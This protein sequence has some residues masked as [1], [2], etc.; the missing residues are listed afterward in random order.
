MEIE[1]SLWEDHCLEKHT[2]EEVVDIFRA[3]FKG[4]GW[5]EEDDDEFYH[6]AD[7]RDDDRGFR[8]RPCKT[9]ND[10]YGSFVGF[11]ICQFN[12]NRVYHSFVNDIVSVAED[13]NLQVWIF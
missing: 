12:D 3:A 4:C 1:V 10:G 6:D 5:Y 7:E 11:E 2:K 8:I 13:N 9:R